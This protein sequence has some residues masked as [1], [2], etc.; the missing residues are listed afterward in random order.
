MEGAHFIKTGK[1]VSLSEEQLVEC[2][3]SNG[4][5]GCNGG[6]MDDGFDYIKSSGGL[7]SE[8][9]YPYTSGVGRTIYLL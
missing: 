5:Q 4:N 1:L 9:E 8:K 7:E 6:L 2:S 3:W